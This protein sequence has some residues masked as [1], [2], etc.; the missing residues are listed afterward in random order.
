MER[1]DL[2]E[3]ENF[4]RNHVWGMRHAIGSNPD[5]SYSEDDKLDNCKWSCWMEAADWVRWLTDAG[6]F[7][8]FIDLYNPPIRE[9]WH[10]EEGVMK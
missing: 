7:E 2:I 1:S 4:M 6:S 9:Y 10:A 3:M 8:A 5:G